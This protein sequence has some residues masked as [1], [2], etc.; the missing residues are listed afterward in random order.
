MASPAI[1]DY[2]DDYD[3]IV[4]AHHP[5]HDLDDLNILIPEDYPLD[6]IEIVSAFHE[7]DVPIPGLSH[8]RLDLRPDSHSVRLV[9]EQIKKAPVA[10]FR[11]ISV[12]AFLGFVFSLVFYLAFKTILFNPLLAV[13]GALASLLT[14]LLVEASLRFEKRNSPRTK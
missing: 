9:L 8:A 6:P 11:F 10:Y 7:N 2:S 13:F 5:H 12:T 3:D 4:V 14:V 1:R